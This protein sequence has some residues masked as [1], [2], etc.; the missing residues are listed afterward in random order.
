MSN[1]ANAK[2]LDGVDSEEY[3]KAVH[4]LQEHRRRTEAARTPEEVVNDLRR[5]VAQKRDILAS[6]LEDHTKAHQALEVAQTRAR[7]ADEIL[8]GVFTDLEELESQF[9]EAEQRLQP[10]IMVGAQIKAK[11][12]MDALLA[13]MESHLAENGPKDPG[14]AQKTRDSLEQFRA[15]QAEVQQHAAQAREVQQ[16]RAAQ[17]AAQTT[18]ESHVVIPEADAP[19]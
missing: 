15:M 8:N 11:D 14:F 4:R 3:K 12:P 7:E 10:P 6:R 17:E 9:D 16:A 19:W 5:R 18:V 13:Q 1:V 2:E